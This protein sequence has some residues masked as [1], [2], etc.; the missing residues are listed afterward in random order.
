MLNH[1]A[2]TV[3]CSGDEWR[4]KRGCVER[5]IDPVAGVVYSVFGKPLRSI[6]SSGYVTVNEHGKWK[7][8]HRIIWEF[9][10]GPIPP[11]REINHINGIKHDNRIANLELVSHRENT[12]HAYAT[13]L[14]DNC[15]ANNANAVLTQSQALVIRE[16]KGKISASKLAIMFG[17]SRSVI[18]CIQAGKAW[19]RAMERAV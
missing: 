19:R 8:A 9:V 13:G 1:A 11:D 17:V 3:A 5:R 6:N 18:I 15:G 4:R 7:V 10:N 16:N 2:K 14:L 12:E